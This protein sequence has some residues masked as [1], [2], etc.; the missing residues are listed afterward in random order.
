MVNPP[1]CF[2]SL[3]R[4]IRAM[5]GKTLERQTSG[6]WR[7]L[8]SS[9]SIPT[10]L[11]HPQPL[12][13]SPCGTR[14]RGELLPSVNVH[15]RETELLLNDNK[16][17]VMTG[18]DLFLESSFPCRAAPFRDNRERRQRSGSAEFF[19]RTVPDQYKTNPPLWFPSLPRKARAMEGKTL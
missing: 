6:I 8:I 15:K 7:R 2:P 19:C 14:Q 11:T 1:L 4:K 18:T 17:S 10:C 5:E 9:F 12:S 3:P 13:I 16:K